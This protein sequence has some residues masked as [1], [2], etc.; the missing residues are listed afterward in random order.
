MDTHKENWFRSMGMIRTSSRF[1]AH[2]NGQLIQIGDIDF[3][4]QD[5]EGQLSRSPSRI[6]SESP[7]YLRRFSDDTEAVWN[8]LVFALSMN[9][10]NGVHKTREADMFRSALGL[11]NNEVGRSAWLLDADLPENIPEF[12]DPDLFFAASSFMT[13]MTSLTIL[14]IIGAVVKLETGWFSVD[15]TCA[16]RNPASNARRVL[17]EQCSLCPWT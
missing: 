17:L 13:R 7:W 8:F 10:V 4:F 11:E 12:V 6:P 15:K 14:W 5:F 16:H 3:N 9:I 2:V 1:S